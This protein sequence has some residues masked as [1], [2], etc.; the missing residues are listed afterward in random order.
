MATGARLEGGAREFD[1]ASTVST[2]GGSFTATGRALTR[3]GL[4]TIYPV[5]HDEVPSTW[6][7]SGEAF[8][9]RSREALVRLEDERVSRRHASFEP[10]QNGFFVRDH[11]S[12]HGTFAGGVRVSEEGRL[13]PVG[14][15]VRC[16]DTLLLCV[17]DVDRF[18][19][20]PRRSDGARLGLSETML[21]GPDLAA[22]WDEAA[23]AAS[24]GEPVLIVGE[25]GSGKECVARML[26]AA[27]DVPG[28][29]VGINVSAI[30]EPL[31]ESELFGHERGA[32]TGA[33][34]ANLGAF[35]EAE[36]GV[37]FLDEV[38]DLKLEVQAK[39]LRALDRHEIR[40]L[41]ARTGVR[42]NTHVVSA[43]S[44][45]LKRACDEQ[46]FRTDLYYRLAG[47]V[48]RVP[49]LSERPGDVLLLAS[50]VLRQRSSSL[51]LSADAAERLVLG[52]WEGNA[53]QLRYAL[54]RAMS[55]AELR[56]DRR[57][58]DEDLPELTACTDEGELTLER[59][60]GALDRSGGI[61]SHAARSLG[62][63]RTTFYKTIKRLNGHL[64]PAA[65]KK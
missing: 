24:L 62:V 35:R 45:D 59:V 38:G 29:F 63:S 14:G 32:F 48:I 26:H 65:P 36:R 44:R 50:E 31:F 27:R 43:T 19:A 25:S 64:S 58:L 11:A 41:G 7:V 16:G 3:P 28:P 9:G 20:R 49:P 40:P 42:V 5:R 4:V 53:R 18:R 61:A 15:V 17:A 30:P 60:Q 56:S 51:K 2:A 21:A 37:L 55:R 33:V 10:R 39:L 52:R 22:V 8:V 54:A 34:S 23:R 12:R 46:A 13:V 1:T 6:C 47:I 57:I